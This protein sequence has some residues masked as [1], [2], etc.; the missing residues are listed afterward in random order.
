MERICEELALSLPAF[1]LPSHGLD[2]IQKPTQVYKLVTKGIGQ[3]SLHLLLIWMLGLSVKD[4]LTSK[5][6]PATSCEYFEPGAWPCL[7]P[8]CDFFR[9][10]VIQG[11]AKVT[12]RSGQ[13]AGVFSCTCGYTYSRR[14]PD[15]EGSSR[16]LPE[17]VITRGS[18]WEAELVERW[19][20]NKT[21]SEIASSLGGTKAVVRRVAERIGLSLHRPFAKRSLQPLTHPRPKMTRCEYLHKY[22]NELLEQLEKNPTYSRQ[23]LR[24][25][26]R[27]RTLKWL[28][29]YD[30]DWLLSVLPPS[31]SGF[32]S[33]SSVDWET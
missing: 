29:K 4:F 14:G 11:Y 27:Q 30:R 16:Y 28:W 33:S 32:V 23:M 7:N 10:D 21:L 9:V 2:N 12:R 6:S 8:V 31:R 5:C 13:L 24:R 1:S 20:S 18:V 3:P 17:K 26:L 25:E 22:R 15:I 19:N